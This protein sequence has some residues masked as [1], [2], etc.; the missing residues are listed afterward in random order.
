MIVRFTLIALKSRAENRTVTKEMEATRVDKLM[1]DTGYCR[2][3][4]LKTH[5]EFLG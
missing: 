1:F 3:H 2:V 4:P 5:Y